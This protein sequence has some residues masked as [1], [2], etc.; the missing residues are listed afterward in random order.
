MLG[1]KV[2][3]YGPPIW[4]RTH[5]VAGANKRAAARRARMDGQR[6]DPVGGV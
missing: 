3:I 6:R 5:R 1:D 2:G 4:H